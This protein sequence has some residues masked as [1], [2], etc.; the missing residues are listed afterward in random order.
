LPWAK[1]VV[2]ADFESIT[3]P[4][5][6]QHPIAYCLYCP[7][8]YRKF[9]CLE[10]LIKRCDPNEDKLCAQLCKDLNLIYYKASQRLQFCIKLQQLTEEQEANFQ[11][12]DKCEF[13]NQEFSDTN[14]KCR[15]H[16]HTTGEYIGAYC[17]NCNLKMKYVNFKIRVVFHNFTGYD[18]HFIIRLAL[19]VLKIPSQYQFMIGTSNERLSYIQYDRFI[20]M[21][22]A[23]HLKD[24]LEN[25]VDITPKGEFYNFMK[26][27]LNPI[28]R[29]KGVFPYEYLI[30]SRNSMK[31]NYLRKNVSD[32]LSRILKYLMKNINMHNKSGMR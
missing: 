16:D 27:E 23:Q 3:T 13:C 14:K 2:Y 5:G 18:G 12:A 19:K 22:S 25:L 26:L 4:D 6:K 17:N 20:F 24:S 7:D 8:L 11:E 21:D 9:K 29:R 31:Q 1:F 30:N 15:H 32:Q 10:G 28:M